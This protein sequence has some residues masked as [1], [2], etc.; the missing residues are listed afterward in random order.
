[1]IRAVCV[2]LLL[3]GAQALSAED[4]GVEVPLDV[5]E[6]PFS[7]FDWTWMNGSNPQPASL[8]RVGPVTGTFFVDVAYAW[9]F[10]NPVDNTIFPTTTAPRHREFNLNLAY[11]GVELS[12]LDTPYG[13]PIGRLE[14]QMGSYIATIHGQDTTSTRGFFLSNPALAFVK[15][16]GAGWHFHWRHGL[17]VEVGIFPSYI[18]LESYVPQ[19]NW[20]YTHPFVSDFTPYF[21]AGLR[22]Q[23]F[24]SENQKLELWLVNGWQSFG[25]WHDALTGG[26]LYNVRPSRRLSLTHT[27]YAGQEQTR[28]SD[29]TSQS[30][31]LYTDNYVQ[32]LVFE[33]LE[34]PVFQRLALC[35]VADFG[36]EFRGPRA[37]QPVD[38]R[39]TPPNGVMVG[40]SLTARVEW[41]RWLMTTV[42]GDVFYDQSA[43]V[44]YP[45]PLGNPWSLPGNG[46]ATNP[47]EFLG[48]GM[49][50]TIDFKPSPWLMVR[51]EYA[52]REAN[53]PYFSGRG[54]ITG[55][56]GL[57]P[58][59]DAAR[60]AFTPDL[61]T[62]DDRLVGN[63]TLRL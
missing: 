48:G 38:G 1:M 49:A 27:L 56:N 37:G 42:R 46:S 33:G 31:R 5:S 9:Q 3:G 61:R 12:G 14:L 54:G 60:A 4:G 63:V 25:R 51:L 34:R 10:S 6:P 55:P 7:R 8:L 22:T 19:E 43:A 58:V 57:P 45:L 36:Y 47:F 52:H 16:A 24:F 41:T 59:D 17:N 15:Q 30:F 20:N 39:P 40:A 11:L 32:W 21:F 44:V 26:Y 13:G 35:L 29:P 28:A 53:Q 62:N 50:A 18:A 23:L 2:A